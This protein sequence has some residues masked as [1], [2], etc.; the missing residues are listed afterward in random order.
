MPMLMDEVVRGLRAL[1][2][3]AVRS[4]LDRNE[5]AHGIKQ[6]VLVES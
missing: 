5:P 4:P 1:G 2:A 6:R 3:A